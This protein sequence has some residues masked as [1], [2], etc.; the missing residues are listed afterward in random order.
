MNITELLKAGSDRYP[1]RPALLCGDEIYTYG[2]L[3]E[4]MRHM[5][6]WLKLQGVTAG[7][8]VLLLLPNS[9]EFVLG[10]LGTAALGASSVP[11]NHTLR[12]HELSYILGDC[13]PTLAL[14]QARNA[15]VLQAAVKEAG[16]RTI[17]AVVD[18]T[19]DNP[20]LLEVIQSASPADPDGE[21][22]ETEAALI[23]TRAED[24]Y[25]KGARLSQRAIRRNA[26]MTVE[27]WQ[28]TPGEMVVAVLPL[29]HTYGLT[30]GIFSPLARG[31]SI[32]LI[33]HFNP[34]DICARIQQHRP[35][36]FTGV[37]TMYAAML[38]F[39]D[40]G[41]YDLGS[42]RL[43]IT[44]GMAMAP[45]LQIA[46]ER[47]IGKPMYEGYGLTENAPCAAFNWL[48]HP[49][50]LGSIGRILRGM[51]G[52]I[53]DPEGRELPRG[54][55]GELLIK[56]DSI[57]LGYLGHPEL[58]AATVVNGWLHTGDIGRMDED[59]YVFLTGRSRDMFLTGGFNVY[60]KEVERLLLLHPKVAAAVVTG[61]PDP[62]YG[63][64][65][66]AVVTAE[67]GTELTPDEL[68]SYSRRV[69]AMYKIPRS[70][71]VVG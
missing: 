25:P 18:E 3:W 30:T 54:Q 51:E 29:F 14:T 36:I 55:T 21:G 71:E 28:S 53:A 9:V 31:L 27:H 22:D 62:V 59:G 16:C 37:P 1:E 41:A 69:M 32:L 20:A 58:T 35:A 24:G 68:T 19:P 2:R 46:F 49:R 13:R 47:L 40:I 6:G 57:M 65:G 26:E 23:Y 52:I 7:D 67:E 61:R 39:A 33:P 66:H 64:V 17:L 70:F 11:L 38:G 12:E 4:A 10:Y 42:V 48:E 34:K 43:W 60:P 56:S 5:T 63:E 15:R 50:K 45:K 44:G 8:R